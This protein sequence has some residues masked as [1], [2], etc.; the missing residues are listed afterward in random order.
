MFL[1]RRQG[2]A[3]TPQSATPAFFIIVIVIV[4]VEKKITVIVIFF[5][6]VIGIVIGIHC[7]TLYQDKVKAGKSEKKRAI[8]QGT[9][10]R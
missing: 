5:S 9:G 7:I 1:S 10:N 3:L 6:T 2:G 4:I 8:R